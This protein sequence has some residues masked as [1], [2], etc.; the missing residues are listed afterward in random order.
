MTK[1]QNIDP[2]ANSLN[3][4]GE[5][6]VGRDGVFDVPDEVVEDLTSFPHWREYDGDPWPH[7]KTAEELEAEHTAAIAKQVAAEMAK[8]APKRRK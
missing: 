3:I 1:I 7:P 6:Y 2:N 4:K 5:V 8:P